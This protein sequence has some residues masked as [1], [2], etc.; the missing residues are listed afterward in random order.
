M[1]KLLEI[2]HPVTENIEFLF[3]PSEYLISPFNTPKKFLNG[4]YYLHNKIV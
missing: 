4:N 1:E 3:K 2:E